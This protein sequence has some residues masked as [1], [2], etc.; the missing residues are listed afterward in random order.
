MLLRIALLPLVPF[1]FSQ[2]QPQIS[3]FCA[4]SGLISSTGQQ[5][6][7]SPLCSS[8]EIGLLPDVKNMVSTLITQPLSQ[9]R[10]SKSAGFK[11][12][13]KTINLNAGFIANLDNQYLLIPQGLGP[14]GKV[15]GFQQVSMEMLTAIDN[16]QKFNLKTFAVLGTRSNNQ[17][18]TEFEMDVSSDMVDVGVMRICTMA[19]SVSGQDVVMPVAQRGKL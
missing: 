15:K 8:I 14:N 5:S 4:Q 3:Q 7:T 1:A 16:T 17:G 9:S 6:P 13:F 18:T 2:Q 12:R 10:V 11:L 19:A